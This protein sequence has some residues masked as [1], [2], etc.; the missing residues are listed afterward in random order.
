MSVNK[1]RFLRAA[2][3]LALATGVAILSLALYAKLDS[4]N[5]PVQTP[6]T[7]SSGL[8]L[9]DAALQSAISQGVSTYSFAGSLPPGLG[10]NHQDQADNNK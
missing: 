1:L 3:N 6:T 10:N 8:P 4:T 7:L 2:P 9:R 5:P